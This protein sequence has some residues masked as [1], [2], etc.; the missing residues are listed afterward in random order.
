MTYRRADCAAI[1]QGK[2]LALNG[3]EIKFLSAEPI[4]EGLALEIKVWSKTGGVTKMT[5]FIEVI[6]SV[7]YASRLFQINAAIKTIK[8]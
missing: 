8:G 2:C 1:H 3:S 7:P 5:A 4:E 6:K